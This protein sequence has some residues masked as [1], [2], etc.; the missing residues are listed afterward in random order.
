MRI[1]AWLKLVEVARTVYLGPSTD[2][3]SD[4]LGVCNDVIFPN[5]RQSTIWSRALKNTVFDGPK[6]ELLADFGA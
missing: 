2:C 4:Q 6:R 5:V 1:A 3:L